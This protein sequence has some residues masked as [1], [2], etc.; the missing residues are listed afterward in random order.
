MYIYCFMQIHACVSVCTHICVFVLTQMH[1]HIYRHEYIEIQVRKCVY[2]HT[3]Y[4]CIHAH[5][6]IYIYM[7]TSHIYMCINIYIICPW[8]HACMITNTTF[9]WQHV[10]CSTFTGWS[11]QEG[12]TSM[13]STGAGRRLVF[14]WR[15]G[16]KFGACLSVTSRLAS[17][18]PTRLPPGHDVQ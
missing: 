16:P 18:L 14:G 4:I 12:A 5:I 6:F 9:L 3:F 13:R 11:G 7:Y 8:T 2:I 15:V 1:T 17:S 10:V